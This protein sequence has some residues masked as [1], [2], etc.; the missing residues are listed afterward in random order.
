MIRF[1]DEVVITV[2]SGRG[3]NGCVAFRR[4]KYIPNGGPNGGDGGRGGDVV[5]CVRDNLRTLSH[6]CYHPVIKAKNGGDG[7]GWNRHGKD[8]EDAVIP[9]PPG[10]VIKDIETNEV[11]H[12]FADGGDDDFVFLKGGNG[13]WGNTHFKSSTNQAPRI[14]NPG[15]PGQERVVKLELSIMADIG[16]VGLPNAGKS[17]LLALFTAARPRIA[18]YPFTTRIP[19]LGVL[20]AREGEDIIIADIPGIIKGASEGAGLG[21]KF[22]KHIARTRAL[23]FMIDAS[24][25]DCLSA[26]DMLVRELGSFSAELL[27]KPRLVLCNKIDVEGAAENAERIREALKRDH[28]DVKVFPVSVVERTNIESVRREIVRLFESATPMGAASHARGKAAADG[29]L[30]TRS[31]DESMSTQFPGRD[32]AGGSLP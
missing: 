2:R 7:E 28:P 17:S 30:L 8:G 1:A 10:T 14:A 16:L 29:F 3:G 23:L 5:F 15:A 20:H 32:V 4:E 13:G 31:V 22:L 9:V 25:P 26:Y 12:E 18:P 24:A 19:N 11:I 6:L 21:I 27:Q